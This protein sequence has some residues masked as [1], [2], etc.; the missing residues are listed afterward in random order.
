MLLFR[1]SGFQRSQTFFVLMAWVQK[2]FISTSRAFIS[3]VLLCMSLYS[4]LTH[5]S[6]VSNLVEPLVLSIDSV[7]TWFRSLPDYIQS[8]AI[9][10]SEIDQLKQSILDLESRQRYTTWLERENIHLR[11]ILS[12]APHSWATKR[13]AILAKPYERS[14]ST[15]WIAT[16]PEIK[17]HQG[18]LT[19]E[20]LLGCVDTIHAQTAR[21]RLVTDTLSRIPVYIEG[22]ENELILSGQNTDELVIIH[23]K[24]GIND[25]N[26]TIGARLLTTGCGG[27]FPHNTPVATITRIDKVGRIYAKPLASPQRAQYVNLV[28]H[29]QKEKT[30][31]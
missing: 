15:I 29:S 14:S 17:L 9:L 8:R 26:I 28:F 2:P 18:V 23:Q 11:H 5:I 31:S 3:F 30:T 7:G 19:E 13:S 10:I 22:S 25:A 1:P 16:H 12:V 6:H 21:V 4:G 24:N 27:I 20:G